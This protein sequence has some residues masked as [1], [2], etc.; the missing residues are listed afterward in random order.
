ME[1]PSNH[2]TRLISRIPAGIT[3]L[4]VLALLVVTLASGCVKGVKVEPVD[5]WIISRDDFL[6]RV[7]VMALI[8][9]TLPDGLQDPS[10]IEARFDELVEQHLQR[11]GYSLV[12]PQSYR[13]VW[14]KAILDVGGLEDASGT[15]DHQQVTKA[16][17]LAL[18]RLQSNFPV[19]A[20]VIPSIDVV[21]ARFAG[22]RASW[23]GTSQAINTGG[24]VQSFFS[25][26]PDGVLG[27]LSLT[28]S[29]YDATGSA[30]YRNAGGIEVLNKLQGSD[31]VL[32]PRQE[33]FQHPEKM[34]NAVRVALDPLGR[35]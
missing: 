7:R 11:A 9:V 21:E 27:A 13:A 4:S 17:F 10:P 19:D 33:L 12:R 24:A 22:G 32:V 25:G 6:K 16:A 15:R 18:K 23:D 26:S 28:V 2:M 35:R 31:F 30:L 3:G 8:D 1:W 20:V 14:E 34:E 29:V 5:P